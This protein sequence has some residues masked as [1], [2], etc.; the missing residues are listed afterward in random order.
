VQL[1]LADFTAAMNQA[2]ATRGDKTDSLL[3]QLAEQAMRTA[4]EPERSRARARFELLMVAARDPELSAVFQ[5]LMDQF[6]AIS[7]EAVAQLPQR[8]VP[9]TPPEF[10]EAPDNLAQGG[11][12]AR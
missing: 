5:S 4:V 11:L 12:P 1:D 6:T 9:L 7:E 8:T 10:G 2:K 3:S